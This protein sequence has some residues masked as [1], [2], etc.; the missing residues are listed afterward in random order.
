MSMRHSIFR[1]VHGVWRAL[2]G[3]R[4]ALHLILLLI[5]VIFLLALFSSD[6]PVVPDSA[7]LVLAPRGVIV[8][9]LTGDPVGRAFAELGGDGQQQTLLSDLLDSLRA[10]QD[11]DRIQALVLD[12]D[13]LIG[14]G[15]SKLQTLGEA[16]DEFKSSGKRVIAVSGFYGQ[17]Q[18]L[19]AAHA[20]EVYV[21]PFGVVFLDGYGYYRT[22]YKEAIDKL[23]IDWNVF[24]V[25]DYKSYAEPFVR[26]DMSPEDERASLVWLN[27]LWSSYQVDVTNARELNENAIDA[28][29]TNM[30]PRLREQHGDTAQLALEA[31]LVDGVWHFDQI[32]ERLIELVGEDEELGTFRQIVH[33]DYLRAV[34][35]KEAVTPSGDKQVGVIVAAGTILEGEQPPGTIGSD[36]MI[37]LIREARE[38]ESVKAVV[39]RI[40]SGGGSSF[41]SEVIRRELE[42]LRQSGKP[43]VVSM[44]SVAASGGYWIAMPA[45]EIWANETTLTG[46]IGIVAM[47]PTVQRTLDKLGLNVDGVGTTHLSG[48]FRFDRELSESARD[49][50]SLSI[51]NGYQDFLR[52]VADAR[53]KEIGEVHEVAGGRVWSGSDALELGL[54]DQLGGFEAALD[55]AAALAGLSE[56]YG[57][58]Y[59][60]K[61]LGIGEMIALRFATTAQALTNGEPMT[62]RRGA[63][64]QAVDA[65]LGDFAMLESLND[66]RNMYSLCFCTI[67]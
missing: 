42:M 48:Q 52:V 41:A 23:L 51:R 31:G 40:D 65:L 50:L 12:L 45:N 11:D 22:Y 7:A 15:L 19:L 36:S 58:R 37:G 33:E 64:G 24:R 57:I 32:G 30:V 49:I 28:Y 66:P 56:D 18:Y 21:H 1:F 9:Q 17:H 29:V 47:F 6:I 59:I 14:G 39:L 63:V 13:E 53:G 10:A 5:V 55:S 27:D 2:D 60:E 8:E 25:G 4:R 61:E 3:L 38:D 67:E 62:R 34:R 26:D 20:D 16:I 43:V 44:S 35:A 54:V 46:S